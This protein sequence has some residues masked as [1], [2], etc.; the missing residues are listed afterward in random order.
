MDFQK[1]SQKSRM[2]VKFMFEIDFSSCS[3]MEE[4]YKNPDDSE[5]SEN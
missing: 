3:I 5:L 2:E 4:I 1:F